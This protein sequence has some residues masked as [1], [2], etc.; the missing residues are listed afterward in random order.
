MQPIDPKFIDGETAIPPLNLY[1]KSYRENPYKYLKEIREQAPLYEIK[2]PNPEWFITRYED[3]K[4]VISGKNYSVDDLPYRL[5][6]KN[7][8]IK[9]EGNLNVLSDAIADW[10]IFAQP[11]EHTRFR[12]PMTRFFSPRELGRMSH[13]IQ[14]D[15]DCLIA[16][17]KEKG[18]L[19]FIADVAKKLPLITSSRLLGIPAE[20]YDIIYKWT[21]CLVD[22]FD[23]PNTLESYLAMNQTSIE[24]REYFTRLIATKRKRSD[25][26]LISYLVALND[27]EHIFSNDELLATCSFLITA[28]QESTEAF[29]GNSV[30]ALLKN[31]DQKRWLSS[32]PDKITTAVEEL[33]RY[34]PPIQMLVR[35]PLIE[36]SIRGKII[37]PGERIL[38]SLA[39]ANHDPAEFEEPEVLNLARAKNNNLAFGYGI[40]TCIGAWLARLEG[41]ILFNSLLANF[42]DMELA[43]DQLRWYPNVFIRGLK[44]LPVKI[45]I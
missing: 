25:D 2:G 9:G 34:D 20:D 16:A 1:L 6:K 5:L 44:E 14:Q 30:L 32:N 27:E 36:V 8:L 42:P 15:V 10:M 4:E 7:E 12:K 35:I 38:T 24:F 23:Q 33:L 3:V 31:P 22:I 40:H 37:Q 11:P 13:L 17:V 26:G 41:Q 21:N 18:E 43:S 19:E 45:N 29:M 28:A 39:A